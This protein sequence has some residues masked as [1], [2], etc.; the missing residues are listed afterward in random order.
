MYLSLG[1]KLA[2]IHRALQFNQSDWMKN[3]IDFNT[4]KKMLLMILRKISLH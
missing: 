3:N 2:K 1:M 4:E